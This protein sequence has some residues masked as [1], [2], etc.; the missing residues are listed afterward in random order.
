[1]TGFFDVERLRRRCLSGDDSVASDEACY[2][3][4]ATFSMTKAFR[5]GW[6]SVANEAFAGGLYSIALAF[7]HVGVAGEGVSVAGIVDVC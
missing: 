1:V 4:D 7:G 2:G 6:L 3:V 5:G